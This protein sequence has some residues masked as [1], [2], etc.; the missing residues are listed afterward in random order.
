[1]ILENNNDRIKTLL[2]AA[3]VLYLYIFFKKTNAPGHIPGFYPILKWNW[4]EYRKRYPLYT[5]ASIF[6]IIFLIC[7]TVA[8]KTVSLLIF[9]LLLLEEDGGQCMAI[10]LITNTEFIGNNTIY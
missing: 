3:T 8:D 7:L 6:E 10:V 9:I 5:S 2:K 4:Y 1:M